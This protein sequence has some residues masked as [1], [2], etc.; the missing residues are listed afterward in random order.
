M[1]WLRQTDALL[2]VERAVDHSFFHRHSYHPIH[3][4]VTVTDI[5]PP[6]VSHFN[7]QLRLIYTTP[8]LTNATST[9]TDEN[10]KKM[11]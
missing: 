10:M 4:W 1:T 3:I 2:A 8:Q 5:D 11:R 6:R 7:Y 9:I